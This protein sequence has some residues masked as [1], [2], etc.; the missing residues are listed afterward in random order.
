[1]EVYARATISLERLSYALVLLIVELLHM[2]LLV[3]ASLLSAYLTMP[4]YSW[5]NYQHILSRIS[6]HA[7][8]Y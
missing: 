5:F 8:I 3:K 1:M 6:V 7:T 2:L 4:C